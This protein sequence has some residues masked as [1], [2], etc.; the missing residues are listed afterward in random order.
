MGDFLTPLVVSLGAALFFIRGF[1]K[2]RRGRHARHAG[3]DR[4]ALFGAGVLAGLAGLVVFH[5][6]A[7]ES[8]SAHMAQHVLVGDVAPAL[9]LVAL[10]GPLF[11][12]VVPLAFRRQL[13]KK[14]MRALLR[15]GPSLALWAALL[16]VWHVPAIYDAALASEWVH[17][18]QHASF[19]LGGL[20]LWNQ[21]ADPACRR[22]LSLWGSLGYALAAM[23]VSQM[24]VAVL[25]LSYRPLYAYGSASDQSLAGMVMALEGFA[26]LGTFAFF[27]LRV[28]FRAPL[29]LAEGHPLRA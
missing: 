29:A 28:Y 16:W 10:R 5:G 11:F 12:V 15:P 8:A 13:A 1:R 3:W 23:V 27:R 9:V 19:A 24:L 22:M 14:G 20:L 17:P 4:F 26:T 18:L 6:P 2:L 7:E 25:I 21:L